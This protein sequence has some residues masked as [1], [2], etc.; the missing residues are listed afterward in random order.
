MV[1]S[2]SD[3]ASP[4]TFNY[5]IGHDLD[6][7]SDIITKGNVR[8]QGEVF[9]N[10]RCGSL[11]IDENARVSEDVHC[12]SV[13]ISGEVGGSICCGNGVLK[14]TSRTDVDLYCKDW[15]SIRVE[16]GAQIGG[17][18]LASDRLEHNALS[19][20]RKLARRPRQRFSLDQ[21]AKEILLKDGLA[22]EYEGIIFPTTFGLLEL[23]RHTFSAHSISSYLRLPYR[24]AQDLSESVRCDLNSSHNATN[25]AVPENFNP[26]ASSF[27]GPDVTVSCNIESKG[28]VQIEGTVQG[29]IKCGSLMIGKKAI[30]LGS[31]VAETVIINGT[32]SGPIQCDVVM[33]KNGGR[34]H[35]CVLAKSLKVDEGAEFDCVMERRD[36]LW[37]LTSSRKTSLENQNPA[38]HSTDQY[39]FSDLL[40]AA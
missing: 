34:F 31:V 10:I 9:G 20:M 18:T 15:R 1:A 6:L 35:D 3:R 27:I 12:E 8:V 32:V 36:D 25:R 2:G 13:D 23:R 21:L 16:R 26:P 22:F 4:N 5:V 29:N 24:K 14:S 11:V 30:V 39:L 7:S 33:L 37:L 28:C 19:L 38:S 17:R 40:Q